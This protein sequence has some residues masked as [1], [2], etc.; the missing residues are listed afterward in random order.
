MFKRQLE[1]VVLPAAALV[2]I[3]VVGMLVTP[4]LGQAHSNSFDPARV[5]QGL[6]IAPVALKISAAV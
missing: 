2:V 6:A 3:L 4:P 1:K 5:A